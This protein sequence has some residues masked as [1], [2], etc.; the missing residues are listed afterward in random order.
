MAAAFLETDH[1]EYPVQYDIE[2]VFSRMVRHFGEPFGDSSAVPT[3]Y[4]CRHTRQQ[5]TVALSGDGGDELFGGY[6]RY[7][8]RR[9]QLAYD[10]MPSAFR[11][12]LIEPLIERLP[13]TTDY[14]GTSFVKKLKLFIRASRRMRDDPLA[15]VPRTFSRDQV[16]RLLGSDYRTDADPVLATALQWAGIDP[17]SQMMLTDVQTYLA[18]DILTKVDRMSMAHA[19]EVRSPLLDYRVVE[20]A[21][22]LPRAFKI[23][24]RTTKKILRDTAAGRVPHAILDRSK[25]GFQVPLGAWFKGDLKAWAQSRLLDGVHGLLDK[26]FVETIWQEHQQGRVDHTHRIWLLLFFNEWFDQFCG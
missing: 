19:L 2:N 4:L 17:V 5:V 13:E 16:I 15:V 6:E 10:L 14:Y 25:Y 8:A 1:R 7:L 3:W 11:D 26:R 9:F 23:Q 20:F 12:R 18:E 21:C 24:G 22:R